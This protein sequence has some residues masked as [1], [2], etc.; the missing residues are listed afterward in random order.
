MMKKKFFKGIN[1]QDFLSLGNMPVMKNEDAVIE[2]LKSNFSAA[3]Y[4]KQTL[5][6]YKAIMSTRISE[7]VHLWQGSNYSKE[8]QVF[9]PSKPG[10]ILGREFCR[11]I[12]E[13]GIDRM[14]P[15]FHKLPKS[16]FS[17]EK[18]QVLAFLMTKRKVYEWLFLVLDLNGIILK[19]SDGKWI[20]K[21][22]RNE[23]DEKSND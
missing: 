7:G 16:D 18:S 19:S 1:N 14:A 21:N 17:C 13:D 22:V 23:D 9:D 6:D 10:S 4:L 12:L 15:C 11:A 8:N 5:S 3:N 20:G 2:W